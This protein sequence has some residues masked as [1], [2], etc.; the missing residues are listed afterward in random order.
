MTRLVRAV[1]EL[2][3]ALGGRPFVLVLDR[4]HRDNPKSKVGVEVG[5][6]QSFYV[7]MGLLKA[8]DLEMRQDEPSWLVPPEM[9]RTLAHDDTD[10]P[11]EGA[12]TDD[13]DGEVP[14][15]ELI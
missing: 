15:E 3:A 4:A 13:D 14:E 7:T 8:A 1:I 9:D 2:K 11:P 12:T 5:Q 10:D 6:R